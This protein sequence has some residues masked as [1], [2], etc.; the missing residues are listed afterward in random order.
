MASGRGHRQCRCLSTSAGRRC[1]GRSRPRSVTPEGDSVRA[2]TLRVLGEC[3]QRCWQDRGHRK[4]SSWYFTSGSVSPEPAV[5]SAFKTAAPHPPGLRIR[6]LWTQAAPPP[7]R[8]RSQPRDGQHLGVG[9]LD[10]PG[11]L[12][13]SPLPG[14]DAAWCGG[15]EGRFLPPSLG[16]ESRGAVSL[17][18]RGLS[19]ETREGWSSLGIFTDKLEN[20]VPE[21]PP[22]SS[23]NSTEAPG[24]RG[25]A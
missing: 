6:G 3:C 14:W 25:V 21:E 16:Q 22:P 18:G 1:R 17:R 7:A 9:W 4:D 2:W 24:S 20:Y 11:H 12:G 23:D 15:R 13:C 8:A 19:R 10:I 5:H